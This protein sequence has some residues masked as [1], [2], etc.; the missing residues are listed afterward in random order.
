MFQLGHHRRRSA[1]SEHLRTCGASRRS[2]A[3]L[4]STVAANLLSDVH[5]SR[6]SVA[7][8]SGT[9]AAEPLDGSR[10]ANPRTRDECALE[11]ALCRALSTLSWP[12][13]AGTYKAM[14]KLLKTYPPPVKK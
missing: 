2:I 9:E 13:R 11:E 1:I 4:R 3:R 5:F 14:T 7:S 10:A 6:A 8:T 12:D